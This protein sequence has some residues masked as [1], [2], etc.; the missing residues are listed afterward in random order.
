[1]PA[2]PDWLRSQPS[3]DTKAARKATA[4]RYTAEVVRPQLQQRENAWMQA[5]GTKLGEAARCFVAAHAECVSQPLK[6]L[7]AWCQLR[8]LDSFCWPLAQLSNIDTCPHC[9]AAH[10]P[11]LWHLLCDCPGMKSC[12]LNR[13]SGTHWRHLPARDRHK[14]FIDPVSVAD[15]M[16]AVSLAVA[17]RKRTEKAFLNM[18]HCDAAGGGDSSS[19]DA[20]SEC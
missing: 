17:L 15:L 9:Q 20:V 18:L 12:I 2:L 8:R 1:V 16:L 13:T 5:E 19:T 11:N 10:R 14:R 6:S 7:R 4:R 3:P